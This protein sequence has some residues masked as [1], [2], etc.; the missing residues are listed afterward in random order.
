[1]QEITKAV[2]DRIAGQLKS[3]KMGTEAMV[4]SAREEVT[5]L[6]GMLKEHVAAAVEGVSEGM[7]VAM[8]RMNN[9]SAKLEETTTKYKD[10]LLSSPANGLVIEPPLSQM[11][12]RLR[13]GGG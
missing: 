3:F 5:M 12:P 6:V 11:A 9:T 8:H 7:K 4:A 13:A 10:A 2:S 1:V